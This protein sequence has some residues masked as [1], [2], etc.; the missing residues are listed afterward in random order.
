MQAVFQACRSICICLNTDLI[1]MNSM[2]TSVLAPSGSTRRMS[3]KAGTSHCAVAH[4]FF[5]LRHPLHKKKTPMPPTNADL[6]NKR[7]NEIAQDASQMLHEPTLIR[8]YVHSLFSLYMVQDKGGIVSS[9]NNKRVLLCAESGM[10]IAPSSNLCKREARSMC[11]RRKP[12]QT[13]MPRPRKGWVKL[14]GT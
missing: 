2:K 4:P 1:E 13:G 11:A 10:L 9:T 8:V 3:H 12:R 5:F 14:I 7:E 6:T